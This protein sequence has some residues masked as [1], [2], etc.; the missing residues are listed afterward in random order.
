MKQ[1]CGFFIFEN[2]KEALTQ[3]FFFISAEEGEMHII[4][5]NVTNFRNAL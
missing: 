3:S 1:S 2:K 4:S 5:S